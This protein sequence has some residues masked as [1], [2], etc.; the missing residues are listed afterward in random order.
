M[1]T[2]TDKSIESFAREVYTSSDKNLLEFLDYRADE[3]NPSEKELLSKLFSN[4]DKP[5]FFFPYIS[6]LSG[7][8]GSMSSR[9]VEPL[10]KTAANLLNKNPQFRKGLSQLNI[11]DMVNILGEDFFRR[12]F[13]EYGDDSIAQMVPLA[14]GEENV[15]MLHAMHLLHHRLLA[16][17]EKSTR[18]R[19]YDKKVDG[20]YM[21]VVD[22]LIKMA[23]LEE[24]FRSIIDNSFDLY[25]SLCN[26]ESLGCLVLNGIKEKVLPFELFRDE[27]GK[28]LKL[29]G[30]TPAADSELEEAY[31]KTIRAMHLD[32]VRHSLPLA[33]STLLT[34]Q[35]NAQNIRDLIISGYATPTGESIILTEL[36]KRE[37]GKYIE[38]LLVDVD[39]NSSD[40]VFRSRALKF[41]QYKSKTGLVGRITQVIP[42]NS[43]GFQEDKELAPGQYK[44]QHH[45]GYVKIMDPIFGFEVEVSS[46][47]N[48]DDLVAGILMERN[49]SMSFGDANRQ[50]YNLIRDDEK[51]GRRLDTRIMSLDEK[52]RL[53]KEYVGERENRRH[54][55]GRAFE[56]AAFNISIKLPIGEIR[57]I[58]RHRI[59]TNLDPGYFSHELGFFVSPVLREIGLE[60]KLLQQY[61]EMGKL[62][63]NAL[64]KI[65]PWVASTALPLAAFEWMNLTINFRELHHI[66]ELRTQPGAHINYKRV[67]QMIACGINK[68][69]NGISKE[70]LRFLDTSTEIDYGRAVQELR[71]M[72]KSS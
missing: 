1:T 10:R 16:G 4:L 46:K 52:I 65:N 70:T 50:V 27:V 66:L 59:L 6:I 34:L 20:K 71:T 18:Y 62:Y 3:F 43:E 40:D 11:P 17:I 8:I 7:A 54:K 72:R 61:N 63:D 29:R 38:H 28:A 45:L 55:P 58:R 31:S 44:V 35:L 2:F 30:S 41:I 57:D 26:S 53:V 21:Y 12:V 39:P 14:V 36:L 5:V 56:N 19:R 23:G 42:G 37:A 13:S 25:S 15:S 47:N 64:E 9:A 48:I 69:L 67:C 60:D 33:T 24:T 49:P 68:Y 32:T 22:P 51:S